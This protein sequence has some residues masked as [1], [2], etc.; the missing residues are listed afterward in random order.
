MSGAGP[1]RP[2]S[3]AT[4]PARDAAGRGDWAQAYALLAAA[5]ADGALPVTDLPLL[6]TAAYGAGHLDVTLAAWE[7]AHAAAVSAGDR[8]AAAG[9]AVRVS[10]HLLFDTALM[11]PVRG[12]LARAER[13]L[14]GDT[15]T[16]AWAWLCVVRSYERLLSGDV[17]A[18]RDWSA[19]AIEAGD[20]CDAAAAAVARLASGR[21]L[22]L[23]GRMGE[24][25][26]LLEEA[27][28]AALSGALDP[29]STGMIYCELVCTLQGLAHYDLAQ[30][31]TAA[32]ERWAQSAAVGSLRGRCRV[33]RAEIL[34]LRGA[35]EEA[36]H[37]ALRACDELRPYLHREL[38][39]PLCELGRIRLRRGD[40]A[41]AE[42][43]FVSAHELGWDPYP[44]LA[45]VLAAQ[46]H[47][48][49]AATALREA[50]EHP[51]DVPSKELPPNT[52]LRRAPLLE[53][54][55]EV[56]LAAGALDAARAAA[57]ELEAIASRYETNA[58][59]ASASHARGRVLLAEGNV[60]DARRH[61]ARA[62]SQWASIGAPYETGVVRLALA[63]AYQLDG[64]DKLAQQELDVARSLFDQAGA[65]P[66]TLAAAN[67]LAATAAVHDA[68]HERET[69][70]FVR[71]G[72]GW[73]IAFGGHAV[74]L[75]DRKGFHY[76]ARL[77]A[78]PGEEHHVLALVADEHA[79][80]DSARPSEAA[81]GDAG[82][83]LDARAKEVYR[84]R[85]SEIEED[86]ADAE[87]RG[88]LVRTEQARREQEFLEH[89]LA[90]AVGLGGRDRR[91][92]VASERAR[93]SITRAIRQAIALVTEHHAS[94]AEH[95]ERTIRT[96]TYCA[97]L[98]D[99]QARVEW[100][101]RP[102]Q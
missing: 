55:V 1:A 18:A 78:T 100:S 94:L 98:P 67:A 34:R 25:L 101:I 89:E 16:G 12:W 36:E 42:S 96:G 52:D 31:W 91:A 41:G 71:D 19:R 74:R 13:F 88:D 84:R 69:C 72:D 95:L 2:P 15:A 63:H 79:G 35:S 33:H 58:L 4:A 39:W 9:A 7:R 30:Q 53:A 21:T 49:D 28:A 10:M 81:V 43:A 44:G 82:F 48:A 93:V 90:R 66:L 51:L 46:G 47:T 26:A 76:L 61:L 37:E 11:A 6:A 17:A 20:R 14:E 54:Q 23:A 65:A 24:G 87:A 64:R 38:G 32:M 102:T 5:D 3:D 40:L 56:E 50:L 45:L 92:G 75:R 57:T 77:L 59:A 8:L 29:Q 27:G 80:A 99:P 83:V 70:S 86:L 97:Y 73:H 85:L 60:A 22:I 68:T 62:A